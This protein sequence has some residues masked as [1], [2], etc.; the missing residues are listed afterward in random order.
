MPVRILDQLR[1]DLI[2]L[3][4]GN[5]QLLARHAHKLLYLPNN[6]IHN[7]H[8]LL[9]I[10]NFLDCQHHYPIHTLHLDHQVLLILSTYRF[11]LI[12]PLQVSFYLPD[13]PQSFSLM[14][15]HFR[16]LLQNHILMLHLLQDL[17]LL[18]LFAILLHQ[19]G[20]D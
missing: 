17:L 7:Q 20:I 3:D 16:V 9:P 19:V 13:L 10:Y 11:Q 14:I 6:T 4:L 18:F 15:L 1:W 12:F 8:L 2:E 5:H